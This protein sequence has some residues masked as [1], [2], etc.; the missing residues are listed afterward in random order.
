MQIEGGGANFDYKK[1]KQGDCVVAFSRK[2]IYEVKAAIEKCT[3]LRYT[4][5]LPLK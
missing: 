5:R 2:A 1:V 4:A 3:G